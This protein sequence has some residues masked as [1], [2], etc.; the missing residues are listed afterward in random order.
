MRS[1][2]AADVARVAL[3]TGVLDVQPDSVQLNAEIVDLGLGK[4][5]KGRKVSNRDRFVS[6]V[7]P[8]SGCLV[9]CQRSSVTRRN[10]CPAEARHHKAPNRL[11][12]LLSR[13]RLGL[14]LVGQ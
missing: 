3:A 5:S 4:V 10:H 14:T 1:N 2:G 6:F 12:E 11:V 13:L 9:G 8:V 7:W